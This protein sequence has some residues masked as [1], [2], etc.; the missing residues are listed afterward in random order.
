M[1]ILRNYIAITSMVT[2]FVSIASILILWS[3][4]LKLDGCSD[5]LKWDGNWDTL[6]TYDSDQDNVLNKKQGQFAAWVI[7][8]VG[9]AMF[10]LTVY[11]TQM[12]K[13]EGT[14]ND[15]KSATPCAERINTYQKPLFALCLMSP[16]LMLSLLNYAWGS[17]TSMWIGFV[18]FFLN[19]GLSIFVVFNLIMSGDKASKCK[20]WN[21]LIS[22]IL[23][24]GSQL[25]LFAVYLNYAIHHK[26]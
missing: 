17:A 26:C 2:F 3:Y 25:W 16:L 5:H 22:W 23:I 4:D 24:L 9:I 18:I 21:F 7:S 20:Y 14:N 15:D 12:K 10:L 6:K 19:V 11:S 8:W 1:K 13:K